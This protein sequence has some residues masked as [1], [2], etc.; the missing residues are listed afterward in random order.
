[1]YVYHSF[2]KTLEQTEFKLGG[3]TEVWGGGANQ[4]LGGA[5][6]PL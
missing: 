4:G 6:A 5:G 2:D 3:Q 1:M